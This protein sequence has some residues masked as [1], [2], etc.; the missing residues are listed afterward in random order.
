MMGFQLLTSQDTKNGK[1]L[2]VALLF[3]LRWRKL[4]LEGLSGQ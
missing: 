2:P 3:D 4:R 1:K